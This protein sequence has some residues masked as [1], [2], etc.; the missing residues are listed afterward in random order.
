[1]QKTIQESFN[2][3]KSYCE[4]EEFRGWDPYDG[5]TSK[6]F[7]RLPVLSHKRIP[8]LA[9]IQLFKKSPI[10][11][12]NITG[13]SKSYNSK[14][15]ALFLHGYCLLYRQEQQPAYLQQIHF[16][17][18]KLISLQNRSYSGSCWGYYFD[19]QA[20]AFFQPAHTP[21]VVATSYAAQALFEAY[22]GT[23]RQEYLD[24]AL[25]SVDFVLKD[26]NRTY[27]SHGNFAFSYSPLD[28]TQ[29]FNASLLGV[30]LLSRA[31]AYTKNDTLIDEARKAIRFVCNH[32]KPDGSWAYG[33]LPYHQWIDSFHT[34]FNL[35]CIHDYEIYTGDEDF[36]KYVMKGMDFY[37]NNFFCED[38]ASKYYHNK[39]Y[40]IDIHAP[41]QLVVTL[42]KLD[43]LEKHQHL[44]D[45]VLSWTIEHMQNAEGYF[46]YQKKKWLSSKIAYMRWAQAWM[47]YAM[48]H[49]LTFIPQEKHVQIHSAPGHAN[50]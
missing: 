3:L 6:F 26:L 8:R 14:G 32:Q 45:K 46:Y 9:W 20:R 37:L 44:A 11:M 36:H 2:L 42:S 22:D 21:T 24:T 38:G 28:H 27:D 7:N 31:Y 16:L 39:L 19:W 34:G 1:M 17:A 13:V 41:A 23:G 50:R 49:Y 33:T 48:A 4:K 30:R 47:F 12:R 18:E 5:L 35:E 10:N 40:P 15:V 29:V 25:S 43:I